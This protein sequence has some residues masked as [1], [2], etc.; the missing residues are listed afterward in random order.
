MYSAPLRSVQRFLQAMLQVWQPIH[1]SRWKTDDTCA[2]GFIV[3]TPILG[4][5]LPP[6]LPLEFTHQNKGIAVGAGR[7]PVVPAIGELAVA[8]EHQVR[9]ESDTVEAVMPAGPF[10]TAQ[11]RFGNAHG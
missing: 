7:P 4:A 1:L 5:G 6:R 8:T 11:R 9:F 3:R 10:I 2:R